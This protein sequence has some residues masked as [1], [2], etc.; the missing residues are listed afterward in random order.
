VK[1]VVIGPGRD[2]DDPYGRWADVREIVD[3]GAILT[4]PDNYVGFRHQSALGVDGARQALESALRQIL[5][6]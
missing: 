4:R 5:D 3:G 2:F 6:R 1:V